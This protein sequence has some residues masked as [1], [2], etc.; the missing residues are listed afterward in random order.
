MSCHS[1]AG[2]AGERNHT[3]CCVRR[4]VPGVCLPLCG[5]APSGVNFQL[6]SCMRYVSDISSCV[7]EGYSRCLSLFF[8]SLPLLPTSYSSLVFSLF[9]PLLLPSY[10]YPSTIPP[11]L[12]MVCLISTALTHLDSWVCLIRTVIFVFIT[13]ICLYDNCLSL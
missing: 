9:I 3:D 8:L 11:P 12:H 2:V 4:E 10:H 6:L 7:R 1:D 13:K 5:G